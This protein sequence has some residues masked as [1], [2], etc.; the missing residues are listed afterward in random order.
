MIM[1]AVMLIILAIYM[2]GLIRIKLIKVKEI[3]FE[4][5]EYLISL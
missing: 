1:A 5:K 3:T 2:K 4:I